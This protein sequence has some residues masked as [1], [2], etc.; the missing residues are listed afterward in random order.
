[1]HKN[2][3]S[4]RKTISEVAKDHEIPNILLALKKYFL[5]KELRV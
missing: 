3:V 5:Q 4:T 1:V 2:P